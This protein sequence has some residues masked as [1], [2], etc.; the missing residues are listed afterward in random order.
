M[1]YAIVA[2]TGDVVMNWT[3]LKRIRR[4]AERLAMSR[5]DALTHKTTIPRSAS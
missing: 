4:R 2:S 3:Q 1:L 5:A